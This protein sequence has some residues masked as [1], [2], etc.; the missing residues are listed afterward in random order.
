MQ[1][2]ANAAASC[3]SARITINTCI[4][5]VHTT[6]VLRIQVPCIPT[7]PWTVC[8]TSYPCRFLGPRTRHGLLGLCFPQHVEFSMR[9]PRPCGK[10]CRRGWNGG[11]MSSVARWAAEM[12][13]FFC[14]GLKTAHYPNPVMD[15]QNHSEPA[16]CAEETCRALQT[17]SLV[18]FSRCSRLSSLAWRGCVSHAWVRSA[19]NYPRAAQPLQQGC[20][21]W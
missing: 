18:E 14:L 9:N 8:C 7:C 13:F 15:L 12:V 4:Q 3:F 19:A 21:D 2:A 5:R 11:L 16:L 10:R 1:P 20:R 6:H 17:E